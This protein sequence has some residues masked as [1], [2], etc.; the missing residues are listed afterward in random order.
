VPA[1]R[2]IVRSAG[3]TAPL[4]MTPSKSAGMQVVNFSFS[5]RLHIDS[6]LAILGGNANS[7]EPVDDSVGLHQI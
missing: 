7:T 5:P 4:R 1:A 6:E 3:K 2:K